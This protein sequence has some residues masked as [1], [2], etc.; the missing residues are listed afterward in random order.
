[1][2]RKKVEGVEVMERDKRRGKLLND[3]TVLDEA[4]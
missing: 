3:W 2:R 1:M 4:T